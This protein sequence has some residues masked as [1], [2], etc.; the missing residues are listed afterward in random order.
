MSF[1]FQTIL[2]F[3]IFVRQCTQ[4]DTMIPLYDRGGAYFSPL[5]RVNSLVSRCVYARVKS[6]DQKKGLLRVIFFD[7]V[8]NIPNSL[9]RQLVMNGKINFEVL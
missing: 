8:R 3:L 1:T 9:F 5:N 2:C 6:L 7:L 4:H